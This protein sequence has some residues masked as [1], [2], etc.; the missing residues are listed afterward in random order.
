MSRRFVEVLDNVVAAGAVK[1][2]GRYIGAP[3]AGKRTSDHLCAPA[4][5]PKR[6]RK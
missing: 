1:R 5:T 2:R 4:C 6:F 3:E